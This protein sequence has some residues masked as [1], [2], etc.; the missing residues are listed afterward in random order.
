MRQKIQET[1]RQT[2]TQRVSVSLYSLGKAVPKV[3]SHD[4]TALALSLWGG[5]ALYLSDWSEAQ[6]HSHHRFGDL[7]FGGR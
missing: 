7:R 3:C 2:L 5:V 1:K 4:P 6:N